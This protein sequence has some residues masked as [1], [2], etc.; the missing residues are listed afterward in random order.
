MA[1]RQN[2]KKQ[3]VV[4]PVIEVKDEG[5]VTGNDYTSTLDEDM[6]EHEQPLDHSPRNDT[7]KRSGGNCCG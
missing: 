6:L 3:Y 5:E 1:K 4:D 7:P 2:E